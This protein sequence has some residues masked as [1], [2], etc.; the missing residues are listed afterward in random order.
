V[1]LTKLDLI[2]IA[3]AVLLPTAAYFGYFKGRLAELRALGAQMTELET[4]TAD[5]YRTARD[6]SFARTNVRKLQARID[7]FFDSVTGQDEAHKAVDSIL[8]SAKEAGVDIKTVRPGTPIEGQTLNCLPIS[9][10]ASA[11]FGKLYDF[12]CRVERDKV[13]ITVE[14]MELRSDPASNVCGVKLELRVY[15]SKDASAKETP[16]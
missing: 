7:T 8:Q 5:D 6:I 15:F 14:T 12:L 3:M 11:G 9:L 2:T 10:T 1:K 13:V 4:E 16:A